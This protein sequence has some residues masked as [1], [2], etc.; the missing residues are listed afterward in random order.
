MINGER[1]N[2]LPEPF[3]NNKKEGGILKIF[4]CF[5]K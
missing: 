3:M 2:F 5:L 4:V 1:W